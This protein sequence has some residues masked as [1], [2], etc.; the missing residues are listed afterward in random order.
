MS[1][2]TLKRS[3]WLEVG[4]WL[5]DILVG[6][7]GIKKSVKSWFQISKVLCTRDPGQNMSCD[8]GLRLGT[9]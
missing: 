6:G 5:D 2:L 8:L 4:M 3:E 9:N 1:K 7:K